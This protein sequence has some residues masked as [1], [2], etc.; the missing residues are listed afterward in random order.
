MITFREYVERREAPLDEGVTDYL[1][2]AIGR[3]VEKA[4]RYLIKPTAGVA[5]AAAG[6]AVFGGLGYGMQMVS[7]FFWEKTI[8]PV[9]VGIV[10]AVMGGLMGA[11]TG[12][13]VGQKI[14]DWA[15]EVARKALKRIEA[16]RVTSKQK[17]KQVAEDE[18]RKGLPALA[19]A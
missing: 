2:V 12:I 14:E 17:A 10:S 9:A 3:A 5:G 15:E 4:A 13:S 7:P 1:K 18:A 6:A 8:T 16:E 11:G 19:A